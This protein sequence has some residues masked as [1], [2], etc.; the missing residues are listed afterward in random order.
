[1]VETTTATEQRREQ[2]RLARDRA[3]KEVANST[4]KKKHKIQQRPIIYDLSGAGS[5]NNRRGK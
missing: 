2:E 1:M 4:L 5:T 3:G